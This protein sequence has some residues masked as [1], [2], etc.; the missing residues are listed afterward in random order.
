MKLS[1]HLQRALLTASVIFS[2]V[3][4]KAQ[5]NSLK[6]K[7]SNSTVYAGIEVGSKGVKMSLVEIGKNMQRNNNFNIVKDTSVNTDFISFTDPTFTATLNGLCGLYYTAVNNFNIT[8]D[9]IFTVVSSGVKTLAQKEDKMGWVTKL[10]DSFKL[11]VKDPSRKLD[12]IDA[13]EEARLSHLGIVPDSRRFTT[14]LID[15][16]SGNTKG[17]YF[18]NGNTKDIKLFELSW[19]TKSIANATEKRTGDDKSLS[20]YEKQLFRVLSGEANDQVVYAVNLSG[21]YNMSDNIAFSGGIAWSV[22]TLMLPEMIDNPVVLVT[23][24]EVAKFAERLANN[25]ASISDSAIVKSITDPTIDKNAVATEAKKVNKVFDQRSLMAGT[26]LLLKIMRQFEGV[27]EKKQFF[28]VKN[29]QVGW[30]SAYVNQSVSK[31]P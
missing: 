24:D 18:P 7:Y 4:L 29:G 30:I 15:I 17:G 14:F 27:W 23:Y 6:L 3:A 11:R 5:P 13:S 25:Y 31:Q 10:S 21:A 9:K 20:N 19:G 22:A 8:P 16:G 12:L 26:G 2:F 1:L 28:L